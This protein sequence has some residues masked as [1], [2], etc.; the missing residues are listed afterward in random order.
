MRAPGNYFDHLHIR[1]AQNLY[2]TVCE[3]LFCGQGENLKPLIKQAWAPPGNFPPH[4]RRPKAAGKKFF[5]KGP[6]FVHSFP[7]W[8]KRGISN[9]PPHFQIKIWF[10][11]G[12]DFQNLENPRR[13]WMP[14][15][16]NWK[17]WPRWDSNPQSFDSKSN[18]LSITLRGL[19]C[20]TKIILLRTWFCT[21]SGGGYCYRY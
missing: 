9:L 16:D 21:V 1:K 18:A 5:D 19:C 7:D 8:S 11:G 15:I 2:F 10:P 17:K 14:L 6:P 20:T 13:L 4:F 12:P 3:L